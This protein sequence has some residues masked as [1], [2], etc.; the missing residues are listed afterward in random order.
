M[1]TEC[2][3]ISM[4]DKASRCA[5][6]GTE[7]TETVTPVW[8]NKTTPSNEGSACTVSL[9]PHKHERAIETIK[10]AARKKPTADEGGHTAALDERNDIHVAYQHAAEALEDIKAALE[11]ELKMAEERSSDAAVAAFTVAAE[12]VLHHYVSPSL[13]DLTPEGGEGEKTDEPKGC[14]AHRLHH[15]YHVVTLGCATVTLGE[16]ILSL[17]LSSASERGL[18]ELDEEMADLMVEMQS[19][20]EMAKGSGAVE[21]DGLESVVDAACER[22]AAVSRR[23]RVVAAIVLE[24]RELMGA[25]AFSFTATPSMAT[26]GTLSTLGM[27]AGA[28]LGPVGAIAGGVAGAVVGVGWTWWTH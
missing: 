1:Q 20:G 27:M 22:I 6:G 3:M 13:Q 8:W 2:E 15:L 7:E 28:P 19:L 17:E 16:L 4:N 25:N 10:A 11:G 24:V 5:F 12:Y 21:P 9:P 14:G 18:C 26:I 23:V